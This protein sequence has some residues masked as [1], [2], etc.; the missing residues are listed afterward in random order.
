[1]PGP[2]GSRRFSR[3]HSFRTT[4]LTFCAALLVES[5]AMQ[6]LTQLP[7]AGSSGQVVS[8]QTS[9]SQ[10]TGSVA[11]PS[12][13]QPTAA[14]PLAAIAT[15]VLAA[16]HTQPQPIAVIFHSPLRNYRLTQYFRS[17]H[18]AID[19][20][21]LTGTPIYATTVG[22]VVATGYVLQ[23]GGLMV[24]V[25]HPNGYTSY[26]AHMSAITSQIGQRV[27]NQTQIGRV[28]ATGWATGPHLHFMLVNNKGTAINPL[29]MLA[30]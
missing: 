23:G 12:Q 30:N 18:P 14:S 9:S 17:G 25:S 27:D 26:Y 8:S 1:M 16:T 10:A 7:G 22:T 29:S 13:V 21:A 15:P 3:R 20:A 11:A 28:G 6:L 5:I 24:K 19:M 2:R 4:F